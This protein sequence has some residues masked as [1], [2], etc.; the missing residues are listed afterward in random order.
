MKLTESQIKRINRAYELL[1]QSVEKYLR[2][3]HGAGSPVKS[4][5]IQAGNDGSHIRTRVRYHQG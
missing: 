4:L 2:T 5:T 1:H 3:C